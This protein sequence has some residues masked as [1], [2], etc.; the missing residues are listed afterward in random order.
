MKL[1]RNSPMRVAS[2]LAAALLTASSAAAQSAG[3]AAMPGMHHAAPRAVSAA[4]RREIRS[5]EKS[6][7]ALA[8]TDAAAAAGFRSAFGWIPTMGTHWVRP[9]QML[10]GRQTD[11][12][13]PSQLMFSPIGGKDSL[14]GIAYGY[15]TVPSDTVRPALFDGAPAWHEHEDLGPPGTTLVMLHVWFVPSPDGA[16]AGTNPNLP[17][18]AVG[19]AAPDAARMHD[20]AFGARVRRAALALAEVADTTSLYPTLAPRPD[21]RAVLVPRRD[22]VRA[23]IPEFLAAE[24]A[25]DAARWDRAAERAAAQWDA[26][27]AAF[28]GSTRTAAGR[29]RV[30]QVAAMLLGKHGE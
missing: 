12:T 1:H 30:E 17:F 15:Y 13:A 11:R 3:M 27:Y 28:V 23:L 21:V 10:N 4:A 6:M 19:L 26:M 5:V 8:S 16:F 18:W 29:A 14:V 25:H 20:A 24:K 9:S 7:Q 2:L 22:S